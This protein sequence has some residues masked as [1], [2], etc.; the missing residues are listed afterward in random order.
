MNL[1][2]S[3]DIDWQKNMLIFMKLMGEQCGDWHPELWK[4]HGISEEEAKIIINEYEKKYL[5]DNDPV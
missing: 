5:S 4:N 3:C 2:H 1:R